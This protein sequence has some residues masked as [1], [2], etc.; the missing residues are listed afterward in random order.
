MPVAL[1][2][3]PAA[4]FHHLAALFIKY[5]QILNRLIETYDQLVHPQKRRV[6]RLVMEVSWLPF[7]PPVFLHASVVFL[8]KKIFCNQ[9]T[10]GRV[11][12]LKHALVDLESSEYQYL[13]ELLTD[14]KLTPRDLEIPTPAFFRRENLLALKAREK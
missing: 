5:V 2:Q 8:L 10:M 7:P 9:G 12:E 11:L 1:L 13:D 14:F 6:L 3:D 4:Q